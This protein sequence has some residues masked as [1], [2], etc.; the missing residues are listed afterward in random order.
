MEAKGQNVL[1][2][3]EALLQLFGPRERG[4][5]VAQAGDKTQAL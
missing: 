3:A 5:S 2:P 1:F 4:Q